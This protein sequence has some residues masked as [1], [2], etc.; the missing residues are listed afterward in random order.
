MRLSTGPGPAPALAAAAAPGAAR[1]HLLAA[2]APAHRRT[3]A[4]APAAS[5]GFGAYDDPDGPASSAAKVAIAA[6]ISAARSLARKLAEEKQAAVAAAAASSQQGSGVDPLAAA[7]AVRSTELEVAELAAAAAK[8]DAHARA[9][10]KADHAAPQVA[11][12]AR[13]KAENKALQA[14]LVQ[15]AANREEA[16]RK[17]AELRERGAAAEPAAAAA[18]PPAAAKRAAAPR[19]PA[20]LAALAQ[21][22]AASGARVFTSP[23]GPAAVGTTVRLLYNLASGPLPQ[24]GAAPSLKLGLNRWESIVKAPLARVPELD[25]QGQWWA[26][27]VALPALLHRLDF[28]VDDVTSGATDNNG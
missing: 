9:A 10:S 7:Q 19:G 22:A 3:R 8:A 20:A 18:D 24:A 26:A 6:K 13:L 17:L 12:L 4:P 25:G 27:D 16:E 21:A 5:K 11:E 28:V 14:L 2:A 15:L 23:E 1:V